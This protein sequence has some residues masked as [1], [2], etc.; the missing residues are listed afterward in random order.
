M[1]VWK[2]PCGSQNDLE[3]GGNLRTMRQDKQTVG[4][5]DIGAALAISVAGTAIL[6][7]MLF[8]LQQNVWLMALGGMVSLL[9]G[10][11]YLGR[12]SG[13]PEPLYGTLLAVL[14]FGMVA[15]ILFGGELAEALPDPLPGLAIGDSTF[16]FVTPLIMLVASVL[17][18]VLGGRLL[19]QR[20]EERP[21]GSR[22]R[23]R[24]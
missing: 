10:G 22:G 7:G 12:K 17:G 4:R 3:K 18:S 11:A 14:Y 8:L 9:A 16:F 2:E 5:R 23:G 20:R 19:V 21:E 1:P 6:G 15:A 24:V 13:E